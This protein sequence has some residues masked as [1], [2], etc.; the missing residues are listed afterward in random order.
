MSDYH[1]KQAQEILQS[2]HYAT[3]ATVS[4]KGKPWNSPV[5]H[6]FDDDL[7]IYWFSDKTSQHSQNIRAN[8]DIFIVIYDSKAP[9]GEGEGTYIEAKAYE[10]TDPEEIIA[11]GVRKDPKTEGPDEFMGDAI[12]R[13]YKA[14]PQRVWLNDAEMQNGKFIRDFKVEV[15]LNELKGLWNEHA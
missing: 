8:G 2:I 3:I 11:S 6:R 13:V 12:S 14:V 10:L 5:A 7:T 4:D 9:D 1:L 15:S